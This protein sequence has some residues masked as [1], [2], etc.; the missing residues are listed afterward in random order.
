MASALAEWDEYEKSFREKGMVPKDAAYIPYPY[1]KEFIEEQY[2]AFLM[3]FYMDSW[4]FDGCF[5]GFHR[6]FSWFCPC[7]RRP[8]ASKGSRGE[9]KGAARREKWCLCSKSFVWQVRVGLPRASRGVRDRQEARNQGG[10]AAKTPISSSLA[11]I[12]D[13]FQGVSRLLS[14]GAP[15]RVE[16]GHR[17]VQRGVSGHRAT[18][19]G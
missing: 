9:V 14:A 5:P 13:A 1:T 16:D 4:S 2:E 6:S 3:R 15:G 19:H 17:Q 11:L 10:N 8:G 18:L 12:F 7:F